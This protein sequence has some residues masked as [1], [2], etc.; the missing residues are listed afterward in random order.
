MNAERLPVDFDALPGQERAGVGLNG[1]LEVIDAELVAVNGVPVTVMER[2]T[3]P[4]LPIPWYPSTTLPVEEPGLFRRA[5][6]D[7]YW[8]LMALAWGL[9]AA[10]AVVVV[11]GVLSVVQALSSHAVGI[12]QAAGGGVLVWLLLALLGGGGA[13]CAGLHC[14]GCKR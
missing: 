14:A 3:E 2:F 10:I 6:E 8:A 9:V 5:V 13:V 1:R 7:P 12:G 4:T 11:Y